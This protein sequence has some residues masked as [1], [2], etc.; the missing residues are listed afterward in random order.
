MGSIYSLLS[1]HA[2]ERAEKPAIISAAGGRLSYLQ[3]LSLVDE[4]SASLSVRFIRNDTI[5]RDVCVGLC[6]C[7]G[8]L[9]LLFVLA[10]NKMGMRVAP[11]NPALTFKQINKLA[12]ASSVSVLI[13]D[14]KLL[15]DANL[16]DFKTVL[17]KKII[18]VNQSGN[19]YQ[20]TSF[21]SGPVPNA[22]Y[23][24]GTPF[25]ITLSSGSTGDP[26][27]IIFTEDN[28]I[29]RAKQ[30]A[31]LYNLGESDTILCASPFYHSLGQRLSLFP[32]IF[33]STLV[34]LEKFS[35]S[36]WLSAVSLHKITATIAVSSHLHALQDELIGGQLPECFRCLVSSS[37][38]ID[39][40]VKKA[41]FSQK[42]FDFYEMYGASEVATATI[43]DQE[44]SV[45]NMKSV[46]VACEKVEIKIT[47]SC[48]GRCADR[49]I[50][51]ILVKSPLSSPG[52]LNSPQLTEESYEAEFFKTG[53]LG[54]I[55]ENGYLF[56][57][58]RLN[59]VITSG[60]INVYPSDIS[61]LLRQHKSVEDV[62][63]F[64][65]SHHYLGQVVGVVVATKAQ[66]SELEAE[67]RLMA[68]T[69][70]A[71]FQQ[72]IKYMFVNE[73]PLLGSGKVDRQALKASI[74]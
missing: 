27:P 25:L 1:S 41:L 37:A 32:I 17:A 56:L 7:D 73:M 16:F 24:V 6:L 45:K 69:E 28:K 42:F 53:D 30:A 61:N 2:S 19:G 55:D 66:V 74:S 4:L 59:D 51:E 23:E 26:K 8:V 34:V 29:E 64:G 62:E 52:Y 49:E 3:L 15:C 65:I 71:T 11:L 47:N 72:P 46:G 18:E 54:F 58:G 48:G 9:S 12:V 44:S 5:F 31:L 43:L 60:G 14:N 67:L 22:S 33:G 70:L 20:V 57:V 50:G 40:S 38:N 63:V 35:K 21:D 10:L 68:R 36:N 13:T 39:I